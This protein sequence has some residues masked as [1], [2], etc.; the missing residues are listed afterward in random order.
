MK[1]CLMILAILSL[2]ACSNLP[3]ERSNQTSKVQ[4]PDAFHS[5]ID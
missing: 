4:H 3:T 1:K 5:Y 2:A